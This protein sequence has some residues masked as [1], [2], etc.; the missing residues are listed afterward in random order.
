MINFGKYN[1]TEFFPRKWLDNRNESE[2]RY[3]HPEILKERETQPMKPLREGPACTWTE[4]A[5]ALLMNAHEEY[6]AYNIEEFLEKGI[7]N[8]RIKLAAELQS[9]IKAQCDHLPLIWSVLNM[10]FPG[11][12]NKTEIAYVNDS[13]HA[14]THSELMIKLV[15]SRYMINIVEYNNLKNKIEAAKDAI[16][17]RGNSLVFPLV[18]VDYEDGDIFFFLQRDDTMFSLYAGAEAQGNIIL[19]A[20]KNICP[21]WSDNSVNKARTIE[22][23]L[24]LISAHSET[25]LSSYPKYI[26]VPLAL[27]MLCHA[28]IETNFSQD[29]KKQLS[30]KLSKLFEE[31]KQVSNL[32]S[33][34]A[35]RMWWSITRGELGVQTEAMDNFNARRYLRNALIKRSAWDYKQ[36]HVLSK[37]I[38]SVY[39]IQIYNMLED[40]DDGDAI[41]F[42]NNT[43]VYKYGVMNAIM[44]TTNTKGQD[45]NIT[46]AQIDV[47]NRRY[48]DNGGPRLYS[49]KEMDYMMTNISASAQ[50][51]KLTSRLFHGKSVYFLMSHEVSSASIEKYGI[52]SHAA[53]CR[54]SY[55]RKELV[56]QWLEGVFYDVYKLCAVPILTYLTLY[57]KTRVRQ[58]QYSR[59]QTVCTNGPHCAT[60]AL[61]G[62]EARMR[63]EKSGK[64][65][66]DW[67]GIELPVDLA[68]DTRSRLILSILLPTL[69]AQEEV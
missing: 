50:R 11:G 60:L 10:R 45:R 6:I 44:D 29:F 41:T 53:L 17:Q 48:S 30:S 25:C 31:C 1:D 63:R 65:L 37:R 52:Y 9:A 59:E 61:Y 58:V 15:Q 18:V 47:L 20:V 36:R 19:E 62:A 69:P 12:V 27:E 7:S 68:L 64:D 42:S 35:A 22:P 67:Q 55:N 21:W 51:E 49:Q 14:Y 54:I 28:L 3:V 24:E 2:R 43:I 56:V 39:P 38:D 23:I 66:S 32:E 13:D 33:A 4:H 57:F 46:K 34:Y 5:R 26:K 40:F 8:D 16:F